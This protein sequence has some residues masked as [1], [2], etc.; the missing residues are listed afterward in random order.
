MLEFKKRV[1]QKVSFDLE[2]FEKELGKA[3]K[4]L[5][6]EELEELKLWCYDTFSDKYKPIMDKCFG[7]QRMVG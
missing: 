1:L 6:E 2:L 5:L 4:W 7:E 3:A